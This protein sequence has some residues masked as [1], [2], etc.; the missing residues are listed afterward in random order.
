[1]STKADW[2]VVA[3]FLLA[4]FGLSLRIFIMMRSADTHPVDASLKGSRATLHA[5]SAAFPKSRLP[6]LM[7]TSLYTG[8]VLLIIGLLIEFR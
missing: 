7:R 1:M 5:Y 3:G 6:L 2:I 4:I 8:V